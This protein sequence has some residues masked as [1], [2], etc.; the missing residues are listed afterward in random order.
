MFS[1]ILEFFKL[2]W[3]NP[4]VKGICIAVVEWLYF[5][6]KKDQ[7]KNKVES[8]KKND[9]E[10]DPAYTVGTENKTEYVPED[11]KNESNKQD[12]IIEK[13]RQAKKKKVRTVILE[14]PVKTSGSKKRVVM[15]K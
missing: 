5:F 3:A 9:T 13:T 8:E 7:P 12:V 1:K 15:K 6:V 11:V 10:K 2:L 4:F 14:K